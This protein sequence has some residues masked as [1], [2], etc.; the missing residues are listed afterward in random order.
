M[1]S[2]L[3]EELHKH[4]NY[5][6]GENVSDCRRLMRQA[7]V[8]IQRLRKANVEPDVGKRDQWRPIA[9]APED[10]EFLAGLHVRHRDPKTGTVTIYEQQH[11]IALDE[12]TGDVADA[13]DQG[14][15]LLDYEWWKPLDPL[16]EPPASVGVNVGVSDP[17]ADP[18]A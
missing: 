5:L 12:E 3:V 10:G 7:A 17:Q 18:A 2:D 1:V 8:E 9:T 16:P 4:S 13:Y 14:W 15:R 6:Y 11:V